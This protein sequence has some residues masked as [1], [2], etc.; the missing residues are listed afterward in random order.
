MRCIAY[1]RVY[2][3]LLLCMSVIR[4]CFT[5]SVFENPISD[6]LDMK[7]EAKMIYAI[8]IMLS[9]K[10]TYVLDICLMLIRKRENFFD[11]RVLPSCDKRMQKRL[12]M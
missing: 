6:I 7:Y 3:L 1:A 8:D 9:H 12:A 2:P 11:D 5:H 10:V 4:N